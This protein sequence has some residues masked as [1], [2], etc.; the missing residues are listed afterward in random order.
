MSFDAKMLLLG[1]AA[2]VAAGC[3]TTQPL[4]GPLLEVATA[5][6]Q[7][8]AVERRGPFVL[9]LEATA[10]GRY[11]GEVATTQ[12]PLEEEA[13]GVPRAAEFQ[14]LLA[15]FA[16]SCG[17]PHPEEGR[18]W[19]AKARAMVEEQV[20]YP[21]HGAVATTGRMVRLA[22]ALADCG[23][24]KEALALLHGCA[25]LH[26]CGGL[27]REQCAGLQI[28]AYVQFS[29]HL[30]RQGRAEA[31]AGA[32]TAGLELAGRRNRWTGL[33]PLRCELER[34]DLEVDFSVFDPPKEEEDA[35]KV[36]PPTPPPSPV[37]EPPG[38]EESWC[39]SAQEID[40][41]LA[42]LLAPL[43]RLAAVAREARAEALAE[44]ALALV[45]GRIGSM[46]LREN[47]IPALLALAATRMELGGSIPALLADLSWPG[48][49]PREA[50]GLS[51]P[52]GSSLRQVDGQYGDRLRWCVGQGNVQTGPVRIWYRSGKPALVAEYS[53]F[54]PIGAWRLDDRVGPGFLFATV[55]PADA[56]PTP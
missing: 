35:N 3:T 21:R 4:G 30:V 12:W 15:M 20:L 25:Y 11:S 24:L 43:T 52:A 17:G 39:P 40:S 14:S 56:A 5:A 10:A 27:P 28:D 38:Q 41:E 18:E 29:R 53:Q 55:A 16:D 36:P 48:E 1:V 32:L 45:L 46:V 47:A 50:A 2:M 22:E 13:S 8:I 31:A 33:E 6:S 19:F 34:A 54:R 42:A 44:Q 26:E 7:G 49:P 9:E 23:Q 51:C 37:R